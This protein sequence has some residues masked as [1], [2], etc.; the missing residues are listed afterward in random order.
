MSKQPFV[1]ALM[2]VYNEEMRLRESV[3][4]LLNQTIQDI[5]FIIIN[6]CS[7]DTSRK[8]LT[9]YANHD[10]HITI[11]DNP[12]NLGLTKSLNIGL[13]RAQGTYVARMDADDFSQPDRFEKQLQFFEQHPEVGILGSHCEIVDSD[14][15]TSVQKVPLSDVH[16][17]WVS[18]L[19]NPFLHSSVM[20]RRDILVKH[21]LQFDEEFQTTQDYE[22]WTRMLHVTSGA[23]L[24]E[25]LVRKRMV[26]HGI[27]VASRTTQLK[28]H[29]TIALRTIQDQIPGYP[30]TMEQLSLLR[31]YF[32]GGGQYDFKEIK[33][34]RVLFAK[35][36]VDMFKAF[37]K[38]HRG[39]A[40]LQELTR[41]EMLKIVL[42]I[43]RPPRLSGWL[44]M[45]QRI[46][47][48]QPSLVWPLL[49]MKLRS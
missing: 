38:Q 12:Y 41:S 49:R 42:L 30:M 1:T 35:W 26:N 25:P 46:L 3:E 37:A 39:Q 23:N 13:K 8:I 15:Q 44:N 48:F 29:N 27:S 9:E 45:L 16:I 11:I 14:G 20:L 4:S 24:D 32:W 40:A 28:N 5:E 47:V 33:K 18:L 43:I 22:L 31:E 17:R 21:Q 7:T 2:S 34:Q 36:Y 19:T 6:D 10:R